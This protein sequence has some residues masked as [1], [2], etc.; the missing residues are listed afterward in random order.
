MMRTSYREQDVILLLKDVTGRMQPLDTPEREKR[1]QSGTHYSE[2]LPLEYRPTEAYMSLYRESLN[3]HAVTTANA[4]AV[5]AEKIW[6][7]KGGKPVLVSLAR[8]GIPI[9]I[10]MKRYLRDRYGADVPH[11]AISIIRGRG[12]DRNAMAYLLERYAPSRLQFVDGWIGKGAIARELEAQAAAYPGVDGSLAVLADPA[13]LTGLYGTRED[14]LIPSSC[15]NATV[16]GLVS[17]TIL[18]NEVIGPDD[19]HGAVYYPELEREDLSYAFIEAVEHCFP[20]EVSLKEDTAPCAGGEAGQIAQAFGIA[21]INLVKPGIGEATRVLLRRV[22]WKL[23]VRDKG[24]TAYVGHLLRL[25]Q[26]KGVPVEE[27]PLCAYRACGLI[28]NLSADA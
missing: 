3:Q 12:I 15:L 9:G 14:F 22:P 8:A 18:N 25:A 13:G 5:C 7:K 10:L 2:M 27:Y 21:D 23:L 17:R 11:Y 20:K 26:E 24:E 4:A 19:F 6:K 28:R 16:S 1:I